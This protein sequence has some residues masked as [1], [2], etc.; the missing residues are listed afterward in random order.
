MSDIVLQPTTTALTGDCFVP[1]DKSISHRAV[2][3]G[4][5]AEGKTN[6]TNFLTGDD[7]LTTI[8]A[9]E[10]MGVQ[11]TQDGEHVQIESQGYKHLNEPTVPI[12]LGNSGTTARLLLGVLSGLPFHTTL[13]GDQ[14]LTKRPMDRVTIPLREMG[15]KIDGREEGKYLPLA[16][17]GQA[18]SAIT[19]KPQVKSAQVKSGV[20]LAGLL[21]NGT[22]TVIETT[23]TRDHTENMLQAFGAKVNV[24]GLAIHI[25]G[26]QTLTG[27]TIQVPRDISSAAFF[28][29]AALIVQ[30]SKITLKDVGLNPTRTGI[31]AAIQLMGAHLDIKE[32]SNIGGEIIGD[33]TVSYQPL[34]GAVIEGNIIPSMIDEIPILALLATQAEGQTIIKDAEELR[35]KETDR[36]DSVVDTLRRFGCHIEP[37]ADGMIIEG[38][39]TLTGATADSH[40]DH[41]IGMMI[42]IASLIATGETTLTDKDAI[43]VSYPSFFEHLEALKQ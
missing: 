17:R 1:G 35:F 41:R 13:F 16:V 22:T 38:G 26:Q 4:S 23:K 3:F 9:F 18:L 34:K 14:S 10:S 25:D 6:I 31:L 33:V 40:G 36:I 29:V 20:L 30:G 43:N 19:F 2:F 15:A 39:Q 42:A 28:I 5:L 12:D 32:T 11:I 7:C 37:T 27:T 24:D 8:K 21:A